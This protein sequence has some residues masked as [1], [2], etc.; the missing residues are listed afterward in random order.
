M[1]QAVAAVIWWVAV[2]TAWHQAEAKGRNRWAWTIATGFVP[3]VALVVWAL[4]ARSRV[5]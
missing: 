3:L 5:A 2:W 1:A 4:P